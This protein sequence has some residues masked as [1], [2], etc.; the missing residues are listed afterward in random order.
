MAQ[1]ARGDSYRGDEALL[2]D[3]VAAVNAEARD[4]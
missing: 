3:Y 2:M 1:Q 4:L